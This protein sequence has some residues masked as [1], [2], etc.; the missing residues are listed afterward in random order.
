[1]VDLESHPRINFNK[2]TTPFKYIKKNGAKL[3]N[4][5]MGFK[6][7]KNNTAGSLYKKVDRPRHVRRHTLKTPSSPKHSDSYTSFKINRNDQDRYILSD[8]S[9]LR[10]HVRYNNNN[11]I[12]YK[13]NRKA[14]SQVRTRSRVRA[15]SLTPTNRKVYSKSPAKHTI[16][17]FGVL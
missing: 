17:S 11:K 1:M 12:N 5:K 2:T 6:F 16:N 8:E 3:Y 13:Q 9:I 4:P 15:G 10:S 7:T 14:I